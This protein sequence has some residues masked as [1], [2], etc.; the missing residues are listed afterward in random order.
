MI[1]SCVSAVYSLNR[2]VIDEPT[3]RMIVES[4]CSSDGKTLIVQDNKE[5]S[6]KSIIV[7][8]DASLSD[9][10][11]ETTSVCSIRSQNKLFE[12]EYI[13]QMKELQ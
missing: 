1:N 3:D 4:V 6:Q 11:W 9:Q 10:S 5:F 2:T 13:N 12:V 7:I 8:E